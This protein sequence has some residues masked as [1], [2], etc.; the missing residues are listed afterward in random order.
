MQF[1]DEVLRFMAANPNEIAGIFGDGVNADNLGWGGSDTRH[2]RELKRQVKLVRDSIKS[3][4]ASMGMH[5]LQSNWF[6][7][8]SRRV[9]IN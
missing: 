6:R 4:L 7:T 1:D 9:Q 2:V 3:K 8:E 5:R